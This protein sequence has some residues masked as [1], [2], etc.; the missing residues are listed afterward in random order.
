M[1]ATIDPGRDVEREVR[2]TRAKVSAGADF[3]I[4]QPVY[5]VE[6]VE[7]FKDA[8][9]AAAGEPLTTPVFWGL[10][11]LDAK[12][13]VFGDVPQYIREELD[14]GRLGVEIAVELLHE[15]L[16]AGMTGIY[17]VPPIF[18]AGCVTTR[19]PRGYWMPLRVAS[20]SLPSLPP[21]T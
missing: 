4:T 16:E 18:R 6:S 8:Y 21:R 1:G 13:L 20:A 2:L 9:E 14:G 10:Q 7:R 19:P 15:F 12:G 17:L 3:F 5:E 11:T